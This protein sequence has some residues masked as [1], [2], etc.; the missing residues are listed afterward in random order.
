[1][2]M[3][4]SVVSLMFLLTVSSCEM[5][6]GQNRTLDMADNSVDDSFKGCTKKMYDLVINRYSK[7]EH[8]CE[9]AWNEA[10]NKSIKGR[11]GVNQSAAIYLYTLDK[12]IYPQ[13]SHVKLNDAC[14]YGRRAYVSGAFQFY[15][16]YYF[17]TDAVQ[18]L[19][20]Q[21]TQ[22]WWCVTVYRRTKDTYINVN[23]NDKIRFGSFLSTSLKHD[24]IQFGSVSCFQIKTCSGAKL[25]KY[26]T[27]KH[28]KEVLIPPYEIFRVTAVYTNGQKHKM[29]CNVVYK[30]K[31]I[32]K[33]SNLRC[34]KTKTL[35]KQ[36]FKNKA[37]VL[38]HFK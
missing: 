26:S 14:R 12:S 15:T 17:L 6:I 20:R 13:C 16:L 9:A 3:R 30:L 24:L 7:N 36:N 31:S 18:T 38:D 27:V 25:G 1:M 29:K 5:S 34:S 11:L 28:E 8:G 32:G 2:K 22:R 33:K 35:R 23:V 4:M 10:L 37:L 19:K 21:F